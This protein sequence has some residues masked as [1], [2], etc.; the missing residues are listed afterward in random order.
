M[1]MNKTV[2]FAILLV[3]AALLRFGLIPLLHQENIVLQ[4]VSLSIILITGVVFLLR[5]SAK[6]IEETTEVLSERTKLAGGLLQSL[7][8][9]FPD[10]ILGI[11]AAI[12]SLNLRS[13]DMIRA[14]NYAIIAAS[15]TFGSNI[16][17]I[18]HAT[19]CI[20]RQN[21]S[22]KKNTSLLMFP[23]IPSG[24]M[25]TPFQKHTVKPR[26]PELDSAIQVLVALTILTASVAVSMVLF[27][28]VNG[29][30]FNA[31]EDLYQLI[32]PVGFVI[33]FLSGLI[34]YLFRKTQRKESSVPDIAEAEQ[35]YRKNPT[36]VVLFHL[37]L[38][39]IIIM[40]TAE[41]M[42]YAIE[43]LSHI[44]H[45]PPVIAGVL[46][47]LIGCLGEMLVIH[48]YSI[49]PKGRIG[50]ALIGVGMDN[51]VTTAGAAIVAIMGGIFLGGSS[52]IIIF[53]LILGINTLLIAEVSKLKNYFLIKDTAIDS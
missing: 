21:E 53:V 42:V 43:T 6:I 46:A 24:G 28:R 15:T 29:A 27:G 25:I 26:L 5:A 50:D 1:K 7:G 23:G 9:A 49:N 12:I 38:S 48:N 44:A 39:G 4:W 34:L 36:G 13:T 16:Y 10:M 51:I 14:I 47:G 40:F 8:T 30:E 11:I 31:S 20:Y 22:N 41:S 37:L 18:A 3:T 2:Y 17:N 32:Q 52:L 33:L 45:I 35:Y 19:W